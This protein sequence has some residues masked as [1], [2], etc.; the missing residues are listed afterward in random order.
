MSF[1]WNDTL[2]ASIWDPTSGH[3]DLLNT[4]DKQL[5]NNP[6]QARFEDVLMALCSVVSELIEIEEKRNG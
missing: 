4:S 2:T 6:H 5:I 3:E 1:R